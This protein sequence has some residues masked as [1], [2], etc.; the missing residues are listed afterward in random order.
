MGLIIC[1]LLLVRETMFLIMC[2]L[3]VKEAVHTISILRL[4]NEM[5]DIFCS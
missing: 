5:W 4:E 1:Y 3:L 2:V